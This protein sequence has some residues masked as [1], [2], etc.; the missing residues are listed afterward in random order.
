[1]SRTSQ[2][3]TL[4]ELTLFA[5]LGA[6]CFLGKV[7]MAGIPNVEPVSLFVMLFAVTFGWKALYPIYTYV[8]LEL[9]VYPPQIWS[10]NYLYI[11]LILAVGAMA[12]RNSRSPLVW[13]LLS[14][15]FGLLFGA[16]CAP[17][18][19]F[20]GGW[21]Y[22]LSWW[23]SGIPFDLL[24]AAGNFIIAL[25]LFCPLRELLG[26]LYGRVIRR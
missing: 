11:W 23:I 16:L 14:G 9:V 7:V 10:L 22:A 3:T 18:Y 6:M 25:V 26:Q 2:K 1:M 19:A 24:H 15:S 21:A 13:A 17:L 20:A 4:S 8:L 12:L 5:I